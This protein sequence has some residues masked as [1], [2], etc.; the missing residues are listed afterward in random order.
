MTRDFY[1]ILGIARDA[2][3]Q[4][5]K[6]A[7]RKLAMQYHPDRNTEDGAAERFKEVTEAYEILHDPQKRQTYDR[8]GEAGLRGPGGGGSPFEGFSNADEEQSSGGQPVRGPPLLRDPG[9]QFDGTL[10]LR[11]GVLGAWFGGHVAAPRNAPEGTEKGRGW[12]P[13]QTARAIDPLP[14]VDTTAPDSAVNAS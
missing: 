8:Y 12:P 13:V 14:R 7:Y 10:G 6:R 5:I 11:R 2:D 1:R 9:E 3:A 4:V